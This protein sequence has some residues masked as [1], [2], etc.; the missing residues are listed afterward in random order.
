MLPIVA[1]SGCAPESEGKPTTNLTYC[2]AQ[3]VIS[4][5][6]LRCHREGGDLDAPFDLDSYDEV[7]ERVMAVA[8][9]VRNRS[10]PLM[11]R[12]LVPAVEPLTEAERDLLLEW[13][14]AGAPEGDGPCE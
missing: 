4:D 8:R 10:M 3:V 12:D 2:D 7:A 14:D 13:L 1:L 5:K 9:V 11:D 6:C